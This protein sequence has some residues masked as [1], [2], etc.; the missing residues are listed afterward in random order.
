MQEPETKWL[1]K[2]RE[3]QLIHVT[4]LCWNPFTP[5]RYSR[6]FSN[7]AR[8]QKRFVGWKGI[9]YKP[10]IYLAMWKR[11]NIKLNLQASPPRSFKHAS[12]PN[13]LA[14]SLGFSPCELTII[15]VIQKRYLA[16]SKIAGINGNTL[17]QRLQKACFKSSLGKPLYWMIS[18]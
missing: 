6:K 10:I 14:T 7:E 4:L 13:R 1:P 16:V 18:F 8:I 3:A 15:T 17:N 11:L 12:L 9:Y 5:S 2:R